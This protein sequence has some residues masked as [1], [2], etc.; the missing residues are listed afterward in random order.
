[1][2]SEEIAERYASIEREAKRQ[3]KEV[4]ATFG[5]LAGDDP[6]V[7]PLKRALAVWGL[8]VDDIG[9]ASVSSPQDDVFFSFRRED[10]LISLGVCLT[11]FHGTS[12]KA[13]DKNESAVYNKQFQHLG[14]SRGNAVPVVAQKWLTGHP[15]GGAAA[16]MMCG[17]TQSI[18]DGLIPGNRNADNIGPELQEFEFLLYPSKSI[19]TDGIRAGL[20]TSFGF[21]QVGGQVLIVHPDH[22]LAAIE[23]REYD[24][25]KSKRS[26][27]ERAVSGLCLSVL[28]FASVI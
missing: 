1:M 21:G 27:R 26:I 8:S 16:W 23:G 14:R 6:T 7:A 2:S 28:Q 22:L 4:Q 9:V 15:K 19:Q 11:Q 17:V 25:Y 3:E 18:Q 12:T 20:M 10:W 13:N 5:M 24:T